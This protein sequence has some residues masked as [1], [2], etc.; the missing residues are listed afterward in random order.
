VKDA[1]PGNSKPSQEVSHPPWIQLVGIKS[2][3]PPF[4]ERRT[5]H[6]AVG[7]NI[8]AD[9]ETKVVIEQRVLRGDQGLQLIAVVYFGR[10]EFRVYAPARAIGDPLEWIDH[11]SFT[12][13]RVLTNMLS[14]N[15]IAVA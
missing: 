1:P 6:P 10:Q 11:Y 14:P 15:P 3:G 12:D 7:D 2:K 13:P 8:S 4:K 5:G 9:M